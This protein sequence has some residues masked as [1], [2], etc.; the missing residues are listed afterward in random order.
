MAAARAPSLLGAHAL[1]HARRHASSGNN[2]GPRQSPAVRPGASPTLIAAAQWRFG[3]RWM[4]R[5]RRMLV[6]PDHASAVRRRRIEFGEAASEP[7]GFAAD[8]PP[9]ATMNRC[10]VINTSRETFRLDIDTVAIARS[11][12]CPLIGRNSAV[13]T[14]KR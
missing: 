13:S 14:S 5:N 10:R 3:N 8:C 1:H 9:P 6:Q 11:P 12:P 2:A 7:R 4:G